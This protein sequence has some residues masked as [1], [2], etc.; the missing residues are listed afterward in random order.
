MPDAAA[1]VPPAD[2]PAAAPSEPARGDAPATGSGGGPERIDAS[3]YLHPQTLARLGTFELRAKMIVEGIAA[4]AHRSPHSGVSV[5]FAQHRPYTPGDDLRHLDWKVYAKTDKLQ[6]KQYQQETNLDLMLLVDAS[7]SMAYGS[8]SFADAS[9]SGRKLS[10]DGRTNWTKFDHATACAA[11]LAYITLRQGDRAGLVTFS[12]DIHATV[13]RS[14]QRST[15]KQV[16]DALAA[17][18]PSEQPTDIR[19]VVDQTLG[20]I[21]N[22]CLFVILSDLFED[23]EAIKTALAHIKHRRHD[24][25]CFQ[26]VDDSE[27]NFDFTDTAPFEGF[28]GEPG[29]RL[30]PRAIRRAYQQA[31]GEHRERV[32]RTCR[33][34]GFDYHLVRTHGWLGPTLAEFISRRNALIGRSGR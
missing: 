1:S 24:A 32:E 12:D 13:P 4:G 14:S 34:F 7:G 29:I 3:D 19:R 5:E 18:R 22:R 17:A 30:D 21:G 26:V 9:G 16:V 23:P 20:Q 27:L 28:E 15:W 11:A 31:F 25:I 2:Q 8:R 33:G 10:P 6:L